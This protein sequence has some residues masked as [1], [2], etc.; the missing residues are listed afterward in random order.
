MKIQLY[1]LLV[2]A[3]LVRALPAQDSTETVDLQ[4][5]WPN[6]LSLAVERSFKRTTSIGPRK[7]SASSRSQFTWSVEKRGNEYQII[8]SDFRWILKEDPPK[9]K[10][11]V[12]QLEYV[13]RRI[14]PILPTLVVDS[15]AQP[16][17][18]GNL[19][20]IKKL[21]EDE[22]KAIAGTKN[23][24]FQQFQG[25]LTNQQA[26][27]MRALEDWNRM[28][29]IWSGNEIELGT[30]SQATGPSGQATGKPIENIWVY[31]I[32]KGPKPNTVELTVIQKPIKEGLKSTLDA[33]LGGDA[34]AD[35]KLPQGATLVVEN[36]FTTIANPSTLIPISYVKVKKWG[37]YVGKNQDFRGREDVWTYS[38]S[39]SKE[40]SK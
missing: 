40:A 18:L 30:S 22:I 7:E 21:A 1:L 11:P 39:S 16:I 4:F 8:F 15:N 12:I 37:A 32:N 34:Y 27:Q 26:L 20:S 10:D 24:M 13:S 17:R 3:V 36:R 31:R 25:I 28:V 9:S 33:M 14:E 35:L 2:L 23:A 6:G 5:S 38:F 19:E 29:Q